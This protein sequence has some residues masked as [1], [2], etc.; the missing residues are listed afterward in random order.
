MN[1]SFSERVLD[2]MEFCT[3]FN[4]LKAFAKEKADFT[5]DYITKET[6]DLCSRFPY[7]L[8]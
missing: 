3:V 7:S 6:F 4:Q 2:K 5:Q 8:K 1:V